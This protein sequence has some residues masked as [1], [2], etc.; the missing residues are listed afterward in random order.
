MIGRKD[1]AGPGGS[2]F[3]AENDPSYT[4]TASE[5]A[6]HGTAIITK[7]SAV[8][9]RLTPLECERLQGF[10]DEWTSGQA[11]QHR[12]KQIGQCGSSASS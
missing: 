2:G 10:P 7:S 11:D 5:Q 8:V 12:Y 9:R 1:T 3:L 6:R 4:L